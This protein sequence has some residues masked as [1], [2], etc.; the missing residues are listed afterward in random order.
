VSAP[1]AFAPRRPPEAVAAEQL[2]GLPRDDDGPRFA[3]AWQAEVF[4]LTLALAEQGRFAWSEWTA[5]LSAAIADAQA[6]GDPDL[7]DTYYSHWLAALEGLCRSKGLVLG[8]EVDDRQEAW[9]EAY[10]RTPHGQP[11]HLAP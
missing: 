1:D 6:A 2:P 8:V 9:R 10:E 3:E 7:G 4:A 11:V 5:A